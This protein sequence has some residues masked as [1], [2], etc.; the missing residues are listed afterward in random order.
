VCSVP[1]DRL[2]FEWEV[3]VEQSSP[4]VILE[5]AERI[6]ELHELFFEESEYFTEDE[7]P[8]W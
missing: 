3:S 8:E 6:E 7:L 5:T 2:L 4:S 1:W